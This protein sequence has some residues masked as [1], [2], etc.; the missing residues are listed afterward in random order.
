MLKHYQ[1]HAKD[2]QCNAEINDHFVYDT[3]WFGSQVHW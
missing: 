3:E 2:G 1:T